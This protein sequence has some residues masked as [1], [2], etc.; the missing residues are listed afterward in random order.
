MATPTGQISAQDI[1][2]ELGLSLT[3]QLSLNDTVVRTL[4]GVP[5]G[6]ISYN[7]LRGKSNEISGFLCGTTNENGSIS[8]T[9]PSGSTFKEVVFASYGTPGGNCDDGFTYGG[10]HAGGSQDIVESYALNQ[11]SFSI[12]ANNGVF[13]DPCGGTP[14]RLYIKVRYSNAA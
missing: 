3:A 14:K 6:A 9:A 13:G 7:V 4:A 8:L 5:S 12:S 10:C 1:N 11:S 2:S